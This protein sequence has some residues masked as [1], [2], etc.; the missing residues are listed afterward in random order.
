MWRKLD[1]IEAR[2]ER[3]E[4]AILKPNP[5]VVGQPPYFNEADIQDLPWTKEGVK[6]MIVLWGIP[7]DQ[8]PDDKDDGIAG[9]VRD[10]IG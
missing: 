7:T 9:I 6:P 8:P 5:S 2:L 10:Q 1:R 4:E 3:I